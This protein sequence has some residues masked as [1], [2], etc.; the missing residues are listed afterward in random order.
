MRVKLNQVDAESFGLA[1]HFKDVLREASDKLTHY[2]N[3][4]DTAAWQDYRNADSELAAWIQDQASKPA[5]PREQEILRQMTSAFADYTQAVDGLRGKSWR[6]PQRKRA[7]RTDR[8]GKFDAA[9]P[10]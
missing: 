10:V 1:E 2:R 4:R 8:L 7:R 5:T 9:A 3:T 6:S